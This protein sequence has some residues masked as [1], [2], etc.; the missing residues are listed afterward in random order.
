MCSRELF[1]QNLRDKI[2][3]WKEEGG[4]IIVVGDWN[5]DNRSINIKY[6]KDILGLHDVMLEKLGAEVDHIYIKGAASLLI[7]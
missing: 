4:S 3:L 1:M 6:W 2:L 7:L 5:E